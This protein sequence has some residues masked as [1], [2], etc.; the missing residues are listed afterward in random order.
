MKALLWHQKGVLLGQ[1]LVP[2][3]PHGRGVG[4]VLLMTSLH[5]VGLWVQN[6]ELTGAVG[7]QNRKLFPRLVQGLY[8][9]FVKAEQKCQAASLPVDPTT[10]PP[11]AHV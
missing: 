11:H 4:A 8:N 6:P 1:K 10:F 5:V 2:H 9:L 7:T 3:P